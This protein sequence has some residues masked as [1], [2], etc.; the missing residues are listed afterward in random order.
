MWDKNWGVMNS[1]SKELKPK[2]TIKSKKNISEKS[3]KR[4]RKENIWMIL[5]NFLLKIDA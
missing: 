5:F 2:N 4:E 3:E 1:E